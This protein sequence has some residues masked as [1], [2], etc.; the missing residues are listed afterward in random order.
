MRTPRHP[1]P[2]G[3]GYRSTASEAIVGLG[4]EIDEP[5]RPVDSA[6]VMALPETAATAT[7]G[8]TSPQLDG[9]RGV[10]RE[11][12]DIAKERVPASPTAAE[13]GVE[14]YAIDPALAARL[15]V[16]SAELTGAD[17]FA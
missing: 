6:G 5:D 1:L 4:V 15:W 16:V 2:S 8:A 14:P 13:P 3:F 17:A 11:S 10:D 9:M 7:S 12:C